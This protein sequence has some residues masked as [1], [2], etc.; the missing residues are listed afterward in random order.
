MNNVNRT[1]YIPLYGKARVSRQGILLSDPT[2]E[3]IWDSEGFEL[4]GKAKS[5]W[6][7]YY[8]GMR[9]AVFDRWLSSELERYPDAVVLGI[10]CGLDSRILRVG[11][12]GHQWYD[13]DFPDVISERK[14][15]F[16]ESDEYH[17]LGADARETDWIEA[18]PGGRRLILVMEGVSMYMENER[19][20]ELLSALGRH[21][22]GMSALIDCYT[23]FAAK[24]SKYRNPINEVGVTTLYGVD[25]PKWLGVDELRFVRERE[26]TPPELIDELK[27]FDRKFFRLVFAGKAAKKLY[28]LFEYES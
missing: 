15:Y 3:R 17:M 2:A 8:M 9:S 27:G 20:R 7:C 4:H 11:S 25:D 26:L 13:V 14:K 19:L 23:V 10:G 16:S 1:L 5:K 21:F 18:L 22:A 24:A 28:R 12:G 6:L